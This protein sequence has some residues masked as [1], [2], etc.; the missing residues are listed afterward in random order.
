MSTENSKTKKNIKKSLLVITAVLI[1][2][3]VFM[4]AY[5]GDYYHSEGV[6]EYLSGS[7]DVTVHQFMYG[8]FFDGPGEEDAMIF[9]PGAKVETDAYAPI[10]Y[11]LAESGIDCFLVDMP[12]HMAFFG[13]NR[14]GEIMEAY[15][16]ENWYL[17]GHS[18]GGAMAANYAAD[19]IGELRGLLLLAAYPT[20]NLS[21]SGLKVL[22]LY[23]SEDGVLHMDKVVSGRALL[24]EDSREVCIDGGN[25]AQF[26]SY[27][28]Q[29]GDG[30]AAI[31][32]EEQ[33]KITVDEFTNLVE[34][35]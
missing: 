27:G 25:H 24:P 5:L 3:M 15:S 7:E 19:H 26:G 8:T 18:L 17:G 12:F 35:Q 14:A 4:A 10:M 9:Y 23:G 34:S 11:Q 13:M 29:K 33:W 16:Y 32:K 30:E 31:S 1:F 6:S 20:K 22:M 21:D 2:C 28:V